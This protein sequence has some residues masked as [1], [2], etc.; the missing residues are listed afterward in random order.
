MY[1]TGLEPG[2]TVFIDS[3]CLLTKRTHGL[4]H[5]RKISM[6]GTKQVINYI[7]NSTTIVI[8]EWHWHPRDLHLNPEMEIAKKEYVPVLFKIE[9]IL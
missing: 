8:K 2:M 5:A 3:I 9:D 7:K 4:A 1:E 6:L